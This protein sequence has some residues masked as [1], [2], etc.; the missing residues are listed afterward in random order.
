MRACVLQVCSESF[1]AVRVRVCAVRVQ[2]VGKPVRVERRRQRV[3]VLSAVR[4]ACVRA[5]SRCR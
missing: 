1:V 4:E 2:C 5:R 3:C